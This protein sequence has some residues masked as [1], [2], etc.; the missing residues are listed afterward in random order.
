MGS[1]FCLLYK[2][3]EVFLKHEQAK[4][5]SK[6]EGVCFFVD[7]KYIFFENRY[8]GQF[9]NFRSDQDLSF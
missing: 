4:T 7:F 9:D 1:T 6:L 8:F 5:A 2:D 3:K